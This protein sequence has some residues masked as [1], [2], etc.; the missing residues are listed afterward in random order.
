MNLTTNPKLIFG[1]AATLI[2]AVT[3][4]NFTT[5]Q[6]REVDYVVGENVFSCSTT[7][8]RSIGSYDCRPCRRPYATDQTPALHRHP[9]RHQDAR[10]STRLVERTSATNT[11]AP[12]SRISLGFRRA[13]W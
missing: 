7:K 6:Q 4:S 10:G 1:L 8:H 2:T 9:D 3:A 12:R 13:R 11:A 5:A